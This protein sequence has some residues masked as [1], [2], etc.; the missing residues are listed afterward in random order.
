MIELNREYA[1]ALYA[2]AAEN[3]AQDA[4]EAG[5]DTVLAAFEQ[6]P[7][8]KVLLSAPAIPISERLAALEEA[9]TGAVPEEVLSFVQLLC[10]HGRISE[11]DACVK[12]Y[13]LLLSEYHRRILATVRSRVP[14]TQ[15]EMARLTKKLETISGHSVEL[16]CEHD[17]TLLGGLVVEMD[18]RRIDGS[19]R[20]RLHEVKDVM[21]G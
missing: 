16:V 15:E 20:H 4:Y 11:L 13:K 2:I 5:L 3:G 9:F 10:E 18:G 7:E 1:T 6:N 17:P 12:E 14:L 8:Y 19:L 21:N